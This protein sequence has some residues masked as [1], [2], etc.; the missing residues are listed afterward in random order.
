[1]KTFLF[2]LLFIFCLA[3]EKDIS[4][5]IFIEKTQSWARFDINKIDSLGNFI[6][7]ISQIKLGETLLCFNKSVINDNSLFIWDVRTGILY[8]RWD[9]RIEDFYKGGIIYSTTSTDLQYKFKNTGIYY[10]FLQI[11]ERDS[12]INSNIGIIEVN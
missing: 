10:I 12:I 5:P 11:S 6:S 7:H 8:D 4:K 2:S 1:M 3:C 9:A